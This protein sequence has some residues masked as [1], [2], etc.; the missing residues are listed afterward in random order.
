MRLS[1]SSVASEGMMVASRQ[2]HV[3]RKSKILLGNSRDRRFPKVSY[4]PQRTSV[5]LFDEAVRYQKLEFHLL[6]SGLDPKGHLAQ[7]LQSGIRPS[8]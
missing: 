7:R 6:H 1:Q 5:S 2:Q 4:L 8:I 3:P